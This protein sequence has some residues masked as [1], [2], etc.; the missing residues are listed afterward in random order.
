MNN[1][2]I[3][4]GDA[5]AAHRHVGTDYTSQIQSEPTTDGGYSSSE[6]VAGQRLP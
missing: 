1:T 4:D 6:Q 5:I 2:E 3:M